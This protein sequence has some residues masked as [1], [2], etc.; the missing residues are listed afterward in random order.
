MSQTT[1]YLH[2]PNLL[3]EKELNQIENLMS[4]AKFVDGRATA[5]LKAKEVKNNLQIDHTDQVTLPQLQNMV[6]HAMYSNKSFQEVIFPKLSYPPVFSKYDKDMTYGWHTDGP[7][8]GHQMPLRTDIGMTLFLSEPE[9]YEGGEL[10][11]QSPTGLI[12]YKL[13]KGDAIFYPTTQIHR[14]AP[15]TKGRRQVCVS[16]I[17]SLIRE[18]QNREILTTVK[19][20]HQNLIEENF[21]DPNA[22]LLL[23]VYSNLMRKWAEV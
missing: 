14:V 1:Q 5:S 15:V 21:H 17:Q 18:P 10:E 19:N 22:D 9:D 12:K 3:S 7:I 23:Q 13:P 8:M 11:I 2:I 16:W 4:N 20:V 6:L